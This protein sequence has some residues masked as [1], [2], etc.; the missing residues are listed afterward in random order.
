MIKWR[1][2]DTNPKETSQKQQME[3][4]DEILVGGFSP[5]LWNIYKHISQLGL[6]F[7]IDGKKQHVPV[8]TNQNLMNIW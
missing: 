3:D 7:P 8:T 6:L 1:G 5:P 4:I 2:W